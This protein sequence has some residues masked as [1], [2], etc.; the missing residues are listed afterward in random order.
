MINESLI[1]SKYEEYYEK[2]SSQNIDDYENYVMSRTIEHFYN[3]ERFS[4]NKLVDFIISSLKGANP[5]A[6]YEPEKNKESNNIRTD[7]F[8][9]GPKPKP[10]WK[11]TK[12]ILRKKKSK[13]RLPILILAAIGGCGYIWRWFRRKK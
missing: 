1:K 6:Q 2:Y 9:G 7:D 8:E 5:C 4:S 11:K 13:K 12:C 3:T 10:N